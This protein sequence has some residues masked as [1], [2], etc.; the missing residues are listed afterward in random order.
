[1]SSRTQF[2][3]VEDFTQA[4]FW[5]QRYLEVVS[6][7][8]TFTS[9]WSLDE[10][11]APTASVPPNI[12]AV[13]AQAS[14]PRNVSFTPG[15]PPSFGKETCPI[16]SSI[17]DRVPLSG[18]RFQF[19]ALEL[20]DEDLEDVIASPCSTP[21]C[22]PSAKVVRRRRCARRLS[23]SYCPSAGLNVHSPPGDLQAR[24]TPIC[25]NFATHPLIASSWVDPDALVWTKPSTGLRKVPRQCE[26]CAN[27]PCRGIDGSGVYMCGQCHFFTHGF[28]LPG[29]GIVGDSGLGSSFDCGSSCSSEELGS[30]GSDGGSFGHDG[31]EDCDLVCDIC[32]TFIGASA[33]DPTVRCPF[34]HPRSLA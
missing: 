8:S 1:M 16:S 34:C 12:A 11:A 30:F 17:P 27:N 22:D 32:G 6:H 15:S 25:D 4:E 26:V 9:S 14:S 13:A 2:V 33:V 5:L 23:H 31:L 24:P 7:L 10:K 18:P 28:G 3:I 21:M 29:K 19:D 20:S